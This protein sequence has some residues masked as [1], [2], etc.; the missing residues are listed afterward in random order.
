[1]L[2]PEYAKVV[3]VPLSRKTSKRVVLAVVETSCVK[4]YESERA[5]IV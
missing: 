2:P 5:P 4:A 1:M 3:T